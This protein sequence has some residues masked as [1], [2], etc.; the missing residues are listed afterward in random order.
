MGE[1]EGRREREYAN[2][3]KADLFP[4]NVRNHF[5][6][7][8]AAEQRASG[9]T[10]ERTTSA[11]MVVANALKINCEITDRLLRVALARLLARDIYIYIYRNELI[12]KTCQQY[13]RR[14]RRR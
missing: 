7:T 6:I 8:N 5:A 13:R 14:R 1:E 11:T 4:D 2:P 10:G 12:N 9:W 3:G